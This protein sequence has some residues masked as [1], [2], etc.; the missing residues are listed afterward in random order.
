MK[1]DTFLIPAF[2][3]VL[4]ACSALGKYKPQTEV[5]PTLYGVSESTDTVSIGD[6]RWQEMFTD[7][8]LQEYI[9]VALENNLDLKA[10]QEHIKQAEAQLLGAKL[11]YIPTLG[12]TPTFNANFGGE[13]YSMG[14]TSFNYNLNVSSTWQL[15]FVR[16]TNNVR[17]GK[18]SVQ[19]MEDYRQAVL[20]QLI[21]AVANN[22]YTLLMLDSQLKTEKQMLDSWNESVD[23]IKYMKECGMADQVAVSQ[24]TANYDQMMI[25]VMELQKQIVLCENSLSVLLGS[26]VKHGFSRGELL[27]Q[28]LPS[29]IALGV[30]VRMLALR[31]DVRAAQREMELAFYT[32]KDALLNFFPLLS[33]N[34]S[35]GLVNPASGAISP[36]SLLSGVGASLVAPVLNAGRNIAAYRAAQSRQRESRINFD[37]TLLLAGKEVNDAYCDYNARVGMSE[38]YKS[39]VE[40]LQKAYDDT[41]YLMRNSFDKTYLDVLYAQTSFLDAKLKLI[42]NHARKMQAVVTLYSALGGGTIE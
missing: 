35:I 39:R 20:S 12:I 7:P 29:R 28:T 36:M 26:E 19:Q 13:G 8:I 27:S 38:S 6:F 10:A 40:S 31:P 15:N 3:S 37:N 16:L 22:Y 32:T 18:A 42:E 14:S 9:N 21:A 33:I 25:S 5:S 41:E 4:V 30:P 11:A 2:C 34:G 17:M 24:Y 1:I 23:M